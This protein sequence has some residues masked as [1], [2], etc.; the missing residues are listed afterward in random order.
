MAGLVTS[1]VKRPAGFRLPTKGREIRSPRGF[2]AHVA[3]IKKGPRGRWRQHIHISRWLS[4]PASHRVRVRAAKIVLVGFFFLKSPWLLPIALHCQTL[5]MSCAWRG[6][7]EGGWGWGC[8]NGVADWFPFR[9]VRVGGCNSQECT[10]ACF[11]LSYREKL[12]VSEEEWL[13]FER[14]YCLQPV[15]GVVEKSIPVPCERVKMCVRLFSSV[16]GFVLL[17][18]VFL[19][20]RSVAFSS[21]GRQFGLQ[22]PSTCRSTDRG[23]CLFIAS[24]KKKKGSKERH[25]VPRHTD[26]L[27]S[28]SIL[29]SCCACVLFCKRLA[30]WAFSPCWFGYS[31]LRRAHALLFWAAVESATG[32]C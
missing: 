14:D 9:I 10:R 11:L 18:S 16:P 3:R 23:F 5:T 32:F 7:E 15:I 13:A 1:E 17:C 2:G 28:Q 8:S 27:S 4:G 12:H 30:A 26:S 20:P 22:L 24:R 31:D 29:F 25:R 6:G 21:R 19:C